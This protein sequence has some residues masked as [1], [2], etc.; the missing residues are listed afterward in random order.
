MRID[1][2]ILNICD[3][4]DRN[5][6][7]LD[8]LGRALLSQ[9]I[10]A[11]L[12]NLVEHIAVK[13]MAGDGDAPVNYKTIKSALRFIKGKAAYNYLSRLHFSLQQTAS[14]YTLDPDCSE[15]LMLRYYSALIKIREH[16]KNDYAIEALCNLES[17]PVYMDKDMQIYYDAAARV[18]DHLTLSGVKDLEPG[19]FRLIRSRPFFVDGRDYYEMSLSP[20]VGGSSKSERIIVFSSFDLNTDYSVRLYL[21]HQTVRVGEAL[22]TVDVVVG[23]EV[24][25]RPCEVDR[26]SEIVGAGGET[27]S[28]DLGYRRLMDYLTRIGM[29]LVDIIELEQAE[30]GDFVRQLSG[31]AKPCRYERILSTCRDIVLNNRPGCNVL[32]YLLLTMENDILKSQLEHGPNNSLSG[33]NLS[34]GCR[35]FDRMPFAT[36]LVGHNPRL[37][38]LIRCIDGDGRDHEF[39]ARRIKNEAE[40]E[41][42][43]YVP[44]EDLN[45]FEN[46]HAL[47]ERFNDELYCKHVDRRIEFY[48]GYFFIRGYEASARNIIRSLL[49]ISD[50]G[51]PGYQASVSGW[52]SAPE[53]AIDDPEKRSILANLYE[54]SRVAVVYGAAG[55]GKSTLIR[56]VADYLSDK[57]KLFLANTN[58]A[59]DNLRRK[60]GAARSEF[61]TIAKFLRAAPTKPHYTLL[62][63]D[64]CSAVSNADMKKVLIEASFDLLLLVGDV[65]QIESV[66]FGNWFSLVKYFL[67]QSARFEIEKVFRSTDGSLLKLW[68][69][70]RRGSESFFEILEKQGYSA[71]LAEALRPSSED[72]EIVLCLNY[73]GLY[74]INNLN[75]YLQGINPNKAFHFGPHVYKVGDP[76]LFLDSRR[77]SSVLYNNLKG[78][79]S[80]ITLI[81]RGI[82]FDL[83]LDKA[84]S[85]LDVMGSEVEYVSTDA[86]GHSIVRITV[87]QLDPAREDSDD[88]LAR[89]IVPFQVAYAVSIHKAQGLEYDSVRVVISSE[90]SEKITHNIFYTAI[91]RAR[92]R[93][94]ICWS[95]ETE[96]KVLAGLKPKDH[97]RSI[98]LLQARYGKDLR[99]IANK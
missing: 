98:S 15:R 56:H 16:L 92:R 33:L 95:P 90:S 96:K 29:S 4:I 53:S 40:C 61:S 63:I 66:S 87:D 78:R 67:P 69:E 52:L 20:V 89:S 17:F 99:G 79:I 6:A 62:V 1:D 36:S 28:T 12:R 45:A 31:G 42:C 30:Y 88:D 85:A 73:D 35:P 93:L 94:K 48:K 86:K 97:G 55:T 75:R 22:S 81:R 49:D 57:D 70:V 84:I 27:R 37:S 9:N 3:A 18:V 38:A 34:N 7:S 21:K 39:F 44:E 8:S 54:R 65:H 68:D 13:A 10:L 14:H 2:A 51:I 64:E 83:E 72:D 25:I 26:L 60:V 50:G 5:I 77:F 23:Y 71:P 19:R 74:G 82:V 91:T 76:I 24:S 43:L 58:P 80:D 32:L 59:V 41:G 47:E 11:Q 46:P